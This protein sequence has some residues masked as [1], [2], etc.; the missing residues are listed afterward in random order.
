MGDMMTIDNL[1]DLFTPAALNALFP[2]ERTDRFFEALF[3]DVAEGAYDIRLAFKEHRP[4]TLEFELRLT[5]RSGKCLACNL[6]YGLPSVLTR[7]P[8]IDIDGVV[9][10]IDRMLAGRARCGPW[11]LLKTREIAPELH[12][13]PLVIALQR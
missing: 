12:V 13:V 10:G 5:P 11:R 2:A 6:T 4:E 8:V 1:K 3:G 7:H 9:A